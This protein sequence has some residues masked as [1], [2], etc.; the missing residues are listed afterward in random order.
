MNKEENVLFQSNMKPDFSSLFHY[1]RI[2]RKTKLGIEEFAYQLKDPG[3]FLFSAEHFLSPW[4]L[5]Y[6]KYAFPPFFQGFRWE[7]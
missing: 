1:I 3:V 2:L 5:L 6:Y 7:L 4:F